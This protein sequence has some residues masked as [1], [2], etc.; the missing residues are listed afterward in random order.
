MIDKK[1]NKALQLQTSGQLREA[2]E[3]FKQILKSK[4]MDFVPLF[5]LGVIVLKNGNPQKALEYFDKAIRVKPGFALAWYNRGFVLQAMKRNSEALDCYDRAFALDANDSGPLVNRGI[6]LREMGRRQEALENYTRLLQ[7]DPNNLA[8]LS[9]KGIIHNELK[10]FDEAAVSF[11]RLLQLNPDYDYGLGFICDVQQTTCQWDGLAAN[12]VSLS[13]KMAAGKRVCG[14]RELLTMSDSP[15][16]HLRGAQMFGQHKFPLQPALWRGERYRHD[17]IRIAYVSP[18]LQEHPVSHLMAGI[19]EH[20]DKSRFETIAISLGS[21]D[22]SPLRSRLVASFDRFIEVRHKSSREI[23]ELIRSL[24]VDIAVDLAGYT[25]GSRPDVFAQRPAPIQVN[26][27]GYPGTMGT[28]YMDYILADRWVIPEADQEFFTEKVVYLPDTYL[29]TDTTV[30]IA[31]RTPTREECGLPEQ[32][33]VFCSFNHSYKITPRIFDIW[34]NILR[35]TPG[36][37]LWL[38]KLNRFAEENLRKEAGLRGIDPERLIFATRV[39]NVEDHL[40]RY[41]LADLFLDTSPYNAHTTA[42]DALLVGLPVLTC[43]GTAFP[44][45]VAGSLL[46]AIGMPE[47]I[48]GSLQE[49]QELAV[50]FAHDHS[51]REEVKRKLLKNRV[52]YP[53]FDTKRHCRNLEAAFISMWERQQKGERPSSFAVEVPLP[54]PDPATAPEREDG[55]SFG[56]DREQLLKRALALQEQGELHQAAAAFRQ[57]LEETPNDVISL[58]SLGV[59]SLNTGDADAS[60]H[61]FNRAAEQNPLFPQTWF[62]RGIVLQALQRHGEALASY[63]RAL[64]IDPAYNQAQVRRDALAAMISC[65]DSSSMAVFR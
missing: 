50:R 46:H 17:K 11:Q 27:L 1:L 32:G 54:P 58:Y 37:V 15:R 19:F 28:E 29:P 13:E 9:N 2:E 14:A 48:A 63:S 16:E 26:Y 20:H 41:R 44:G 10:Q 5:S 64:V 35:M 6:I 57:L 49:Y 8:A 33:F 24:E 7:F 31:E 47:L 4:P 65:S 3:A 40:A 45:R 52:I 42:S 34:M 39:P 60:L 22:H 55:E 51:L 38:M 12:L 43:Q 61:Y 36:S 21:D 23:A 59:I 62:N 30:K 53:L 56:I 18:D 25:A